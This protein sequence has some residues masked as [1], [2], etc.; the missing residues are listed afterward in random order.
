MQV[1]TYH[2]MSISALLAVAK[3]INK[4]ST[5]LQTVLGQ[6]WTIPVNIHSLRKESSDHL[7][8]IYIISGWRNIA[9]GEV[10]VTEPAFKLTKRRLDKYKLLFEV[11]YVLVSYHTWHQVVPNFGKVCSYS[12]FF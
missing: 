5:E 6:G 1:K 10:E 8:S 2:N 9:T 7:P 4:N 3:V 12:S 11:T